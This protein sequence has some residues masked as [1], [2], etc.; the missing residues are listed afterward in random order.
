[1]IHIRY[2]IYFIGIEIQ[3]QEFFLTKG[4]TIFTNK[5][6]KLSEQ[7]E[8]F[9]AYQFASSVMTNALIKVGYGS[10]TLK[11]KVSAKTNCNIRNY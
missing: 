3:Y 10:V 8:N 1:M 5:F 11:V 6:D 7:T 2:P 9:R 4:K